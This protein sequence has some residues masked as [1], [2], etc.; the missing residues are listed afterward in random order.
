MGVSIIADENGAILY[1]NTSDR[2][3]GPV[4]TNPEQPRSETAHR[5][6]AREFLDDLG[7]D[8]RRLDEDTLQDEYVERVKD[9]RPSP[10]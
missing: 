10:A 3:F 5:K 8:P 6:F 2:A 7:T 9:R 4:I 1:C